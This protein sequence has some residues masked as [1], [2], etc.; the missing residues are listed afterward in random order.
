MFFTFI[1]SYKQQAYQVILK[2][3]WPVYLDLP[4]LG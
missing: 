4:G 2:Q 1:L 3:Y